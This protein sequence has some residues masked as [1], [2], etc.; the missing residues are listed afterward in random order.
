[1]AQQ[2]KVKKKKKKKSMPVKLQ[3]NSKLISPTL[4][5]FPTTYHERI[6]NLCSRDYDPLPYWN[7]HLQFIKV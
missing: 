7:K 4:E 6:N 2:V 5:P 1:M 3:Q